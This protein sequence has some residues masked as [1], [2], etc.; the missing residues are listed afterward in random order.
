[1]QLDGQILSLAAAPGTDAARRSI[2]TLIAASHADG[3][4]EE[5]RGIESPKRRALVAVAWNIYPRL[6]AE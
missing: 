4:H 1:M 2:A 5:G 6:M 3:W